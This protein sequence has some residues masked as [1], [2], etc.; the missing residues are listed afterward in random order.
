MSHECHESKSPE[1]TKPSSGMKA[2]QTEQKSPSAAKNDR[3][4]DMQKSKSMSSR[5][6]PRAAPRT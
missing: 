3:A 4:E 1:A 2:T 5:T 6:A